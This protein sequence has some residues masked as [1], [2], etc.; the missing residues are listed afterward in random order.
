M[1]S[2]IYEV[3]N[4]NLEKVVAGSVLPERVCRKRVDRNKQN[5]PNL[6]YSSLVIQ[7]WN[8]RPQ[9]HLHVTLDFIFDIW[10]TVPLLVFVFIGILIERCRIQSFLKV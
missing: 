7:L 1:F 9:L 10:S 8:I 3:N 2:E 5:V 4:G 6:L